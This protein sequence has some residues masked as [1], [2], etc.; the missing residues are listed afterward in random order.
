MEPLLDFWEPPFHYDIKNLTTYNNN[1]K[2]V[3]YTDQYSQL[4][5]QSLYPNEEVGFEIHPHT[6]QFLRC[7]F[8]N[9]I[10]IIDD[11]QYQFYENISII[12]PPGHYHNI[13]NI[14]NSKTLNFYTIYST[15]LK[16]E[17]FPGEVQKFKTD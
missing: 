1:Y 12:I 9:G 6:S 17:Y 10:V 15:N 14:D 8:G 7:E 3:L 16:K 4:V 2:E 5:I 13:I 11:I